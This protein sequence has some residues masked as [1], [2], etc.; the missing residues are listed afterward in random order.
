MA[1]VRAVPDS[2]LVEDALLAVLLNDPSLAALLADGVWWDV[3]GEG[4]KQF[5]IVSLIEHSDVPTMGGRAWE[6]YLF[7]VKAVMLN[8]SSA[9]IRAATLRIDQLLDEQ[10]LVVEGYGCMAM[11]RESRVRYTENDAENAA[12]RWL[13]RG[14]RYRVQ[15]A[16]TDAP[17]VTGD[18]T[19]RGSREALTRTSGSVVVDR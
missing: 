3:A 18:R 2:S 10:P 14:G 12:I 9:Q 13:H 1:P 4:A 8:A 11:F 17:G 15:V 19:K 5:G 7:L 16:L 6:D